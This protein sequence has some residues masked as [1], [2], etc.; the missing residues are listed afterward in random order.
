MSILETVVVMSSV[1]VALGL[2]T[3]LIQIMLRLGSESQERLTAGGA[4]ERFSHGFRADA[5]A[6]ARCK[7]EK[8]EGTDRL[9]FDVGPGTRVEYRP[10]G[11]RILREQSRAGQV[12]GRDECVLPRGST[13]TLGARSIAGREF[14]V[15]VVQPPADKTGST[16][17]PLE[18]LAAVGKDKGRGEI[19]R[20]EAP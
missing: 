9:V 12:A 16:A 20:K 2:A 5:H 19:P 3:L 13:A 18:I 17:P 4:L 15:L 8:G 6:A 10:K 14:V 11:S 1:A 7:V